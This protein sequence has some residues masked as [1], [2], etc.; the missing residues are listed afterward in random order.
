MAELKILVATVSGNAEMCAEEMSDW[1]KARGV[2]VTMESMADQ[3]EDAFSADV[4]YLLVTSTHGVGEVPDEA[5]DFFEDLQDGRPDLSGVKYGLY[6]L[7]DSVYET[8]CEA[9]KV[10]DELLASL[11]AKRIGAR[12]EHDASGGELAEE[13]CIAW[14]EAWFEQALTD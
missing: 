5:L 7:G 2:E 12:G 8:F 14:L 1:V 9:G 4:I 13:A 6:T 11:G 3:D 10:F